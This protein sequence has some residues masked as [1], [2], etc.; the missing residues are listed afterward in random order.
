VTTELVSHDDLRAAVASLA[1]WHIEVEIA[2]GVTTAAALDPSLSP[3]QLEHRV[4]FIDPRDGWRQLVGSVYPDGLQGRST[5]D[6]ACNCGAYTFWLKELGSG[7]GLAFDVRER[8]IAQ[9]RFLAAHRDAPADG[10]RFEVCELGALPQLTGETFDVSVF[11]GIFYHLPDPIHAVGVVAERTRELMILNTSV[12]MGLPDGMLVAAQESV[13]DPMSGVHGLSWFPT[14]PG[15]LAEMLASHG[16]TAWRCTMFSDRD[17]VVGELGRVELLAA[18]TEDTF[19][20]FDAQR[21]RLGPNHAFNAFS[22][23]NSAAAAGD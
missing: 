1:P 12:R 20:T 7:G 9:A 19:A 18:R 5:L 10:L 16:F 6:C 17:E 14:G 2:D 21:S 23:H 8:W 22:R 15:V 3:A 11:K 13:V 4:S